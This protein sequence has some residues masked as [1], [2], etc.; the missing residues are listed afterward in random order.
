LLVGDLAFFMGCFSVALLLGR[1]APSAV[2]IPAAIVLVFAYAGYVR[3][4]FRHSGP[5][6]TEGEIRPLILDATR[7]DPP[8]MGTV[9]YS[10]L[11]RSERSSAALIFSLSRPSTSP[12]VW[13]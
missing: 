13:V 3:R 10:S 2:R 12:T 5:V 11:S 6:E 4:T 9:L 8:S 1:G 7:S